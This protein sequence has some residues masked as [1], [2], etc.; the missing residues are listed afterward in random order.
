V[1][2]I[3]PRPMVRGA[4]QRCSRTLLKVDI[5]NSDGISD[6]WQWT[7]EPSLQRHEL[8][9]DGDGEFRMPPERSSKEFIY[10]AQ[11]TSTSRQ[12]ILKLYTHVEGT[13]TK[14]ESFG[15]Y[16]YSFAAICTRVNIAK[17]THPPLQYDT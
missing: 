1:F 6:W 11:N 8:G 7:V 17:P 13:I 15:G 9:L 2:Q 4:V 12:Q 3:H 5:E 14:D 10:S 16:W